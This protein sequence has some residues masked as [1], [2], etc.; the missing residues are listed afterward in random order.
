MFVATSTPNQQ[1]IGVIGESSSHK[2]S[3]NN[4]E[5]KHPIPIQSSSII[6]PSSLG[7]VSQMI[8]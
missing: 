2:S 7:S 1:D 8:L 6:K 5:I 3:H 4:L